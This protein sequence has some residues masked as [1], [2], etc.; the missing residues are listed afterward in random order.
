M[1]LSFLF[2]SLG[3]MR[4]LQAEEA[5]AT[6]PSLFRTHEGGQRIR[7]VLRRKCLSPSLE[8]EVERK[9]A[10]FSSGV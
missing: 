1:F 10:L 2:L 3:D 4:C 6:N 5:A 8:L 9:F 7:E